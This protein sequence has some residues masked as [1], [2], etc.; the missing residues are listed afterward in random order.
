MRHAQAGHVPGPDKER[1]LTAAGAVDAA[2]AGRW[3]LAQGWLPT[4]VACSPARRTRETYEAVAKQWPE[5]PEPR[6]V[7]ALYEGH[8]A[9]YR[10]LLQDAGT[11]LVVGHNPTIEVLAR[12]ISPHA[13]R[14]APGTVACFDESRLAALFEP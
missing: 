8:L 10:G 12:S 13:P 6:F 11:T 5:A 7:E 3:L 1:P 14:M 4:A 9:D 2:A